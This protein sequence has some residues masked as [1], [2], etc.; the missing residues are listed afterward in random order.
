MLATKSVNVENH[1]KLAVWQIIVVR[2]LCSLYD[3]IYDTIRTVWGLSFVPPCICSYIVCWWIVD[4]LNSKCDA[5]AIMLGAHYHTNST[6][7]SWTWLRFIGP[8]PQKVRAY[9]TRPTYWTEWVTS[10]PTRPGPM[11]VWRLAKNN[12]FLNQKWINYWHFAI[13]HFFINLQIFSNNRLHC[14]FVGLMCT[15]AGRRTVSWVP[16]CSPC[17][18]ARAVYNFTHA[19]IELVAGR[20]TIKVWKQANRWP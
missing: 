18:A 1:D 9:P 20:L 2:T 5:T 10:D 6:H 8:D 14:F 3:M 12:S 4:I 13:Y 11:P 15:R 16:D 17:L 19:L 7:Q